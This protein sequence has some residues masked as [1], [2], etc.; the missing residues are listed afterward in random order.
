MT[1]APKPSSTAFPLTNADNQKKKEKQNE[2][3]ITKLINL[4]RLSIHI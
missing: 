4:I 2:K 1:V 3:L